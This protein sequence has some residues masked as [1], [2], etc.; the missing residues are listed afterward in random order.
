MIR[1]NYGRVENP[2]LGFSTARGYNSEDRVRS[3]EIWLIGSCGRVT[4]E[5]KES[6]GAAAFPIGMMRTKVDGRGRRMFLGLTD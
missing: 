1:A 2:S 5:E 6:T 3:F 4:S